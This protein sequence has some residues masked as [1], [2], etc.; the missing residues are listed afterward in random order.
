MYNF[1]AFLQSNQL[2]WIEHYFNDCSIIKPIIVTLRWKMAKNNIGVIGF[3]KKGEQFNSGQIVKTVSIVDALKELPNTK[4][5]IMNTYKWKTRG[6]SLFFKIFFSFFKCKN[7][8]LITAQKG[9]RVFTPLLSF[10]NKIFRRRI[11]YIVIGG[12]IGQKVAKQKALKRIGKFYKVYVETTKIQEELAT[13]GINNTAILNNFKDLPLASDEDLNKVHEK[14]FNICYFSRVE[15]EKG[16]EDIINVLEDINKEEI[17][18]KLTIYGVIRPNYKEDFLT[19]VAKHSNYVEYAGVI[20][21][22]QSVTTIKDYFL[23]IFPTRYATEGIPG[24]IIDSYFAGVPVIAARWNSFEEIIAEG[25]TGL[26]YP[27]KDSKALQT[28]LE[29]VIEEPQIISDMKRN[30]QQKASEY[31][32]DHFLQVFSEHLL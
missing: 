32:K 7:I 31:S 8:I 3:Y 13:L 9:I 24:S 16:V 17:K 6:I 18:C 12:W 30:C 28:L 20:K 15:P 2:K 10:L 26:G 29:K 4:V 11:H 1:I 5:T 25:Q 23:Q 27:L 21:Y 19:L 14:P 22:D